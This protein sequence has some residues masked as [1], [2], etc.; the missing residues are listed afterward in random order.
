M[1]Q[2]MNDTFRIALRAM[3]VAAMT[4]LAGST[5]TAQVEVHGNVYGGGNLADVKENTAVNMSAGQVY[6]NVYGGGKGKA[7]NFKCDKAMVGEEKQENA[8]ANPASDDNKDK[9]TRVTYLR[10]E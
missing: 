10:K 2:D 6:G 3:V 1:K 4:L 9:G 5:A 8:C 7:D